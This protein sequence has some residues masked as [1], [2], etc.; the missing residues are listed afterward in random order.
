MVPFYIDGG[1]MYEILFA[2]H[3]SYHTATGRLRCCGT[4]GTSRRVRASQLRHRRHSAD[5]SRTP[6]PVICGPW[7][8]S[9]TLCSLAPLLL[10]SRV[11]A[12]HVVSISLVGYVNIASCSSHAADSWG[13]SY[14]QSAHH[15]LTRLIHTLTYCTYYSG[16]NARGDAAASAEREV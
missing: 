6:R 14:A 8:S 11:G 15:S 3:S 5:R 13:M 12:V 9:C 7:E 2:C 10:P 4:S 1:R 16:H